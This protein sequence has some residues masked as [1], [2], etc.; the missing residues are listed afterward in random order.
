MEQFNN[1]DHFHLKTS[2]G[3]NDAWQS[4]VVNLRTSDWTMLK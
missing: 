3:Q 4:I 2:T 1:Y